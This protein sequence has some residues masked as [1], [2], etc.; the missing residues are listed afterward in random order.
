MVQR[1]P[2]S[3]RI[4][5]ADPRAPSQE[6]WDRMTAE[7]RAR[8]V[9]MLPAEVPIE[10]VVKLGARLDQALRNKQDAEERANAE[11][12]RAAAEAERASAEAARASAEA[13]RAQALQQQLTEVERKLAAAEAEIARLK[14]G[15]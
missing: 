4:D 14:R 1:L 15:E 9:A 7:E 13:E 8:V 11:A 10:L 6:V 12:A 5:P 2:E 3:Y